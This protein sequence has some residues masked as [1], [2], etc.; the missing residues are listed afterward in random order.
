[1][2]SSKNRGIRIELDGEF[3]ED[4]GDVIEQKVERGVKKLEESLKD[5]KGLEIRIEQPGEKTSRKRRGRESAAQISGPIAI[6]PET[7][8]EKRERF[9]KA[10]VSPGALFTFGGMMIPGLITF[11]EGIG[12]AF[13]VAGFIF[14]VAI[15]AGEYSALEARRERKLRRMI[16]QGE[17]P[18]Y[19][20]EATPISLPQA[21]AT[22][23]AVTDPDS[24]RARMDALI[25]RIRSRMDE[26][27]PAISV[28]ELGRYSELASHYEAKAIEIR[29]Y[30]NEVGGL[31]EAQTDLARLR[32][33]QEQLAPGDA[34][35]ESL[36]KLISIKERTVRDFQALERY[37]ATVE[38][39]FEEQIA[40]LESLDAALM[41]HK[42]GSFARQT[43]ADETLSTRE[44]ESLALGLSQTA[45]A[46]EQDLA[47]I[48]VE[49]A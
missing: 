37:L 41:R 1:M 7:D 42:L 25:S 17:L 30:L 45:D 15:A 40:H 5:F 31:A 12:I 27:Q 22:H 46:L 26:D 14:Y 9:W 2:G 35:A 34:R 36:A 10:V 11:Q 21:Y 8:V 3:L 4:I 33:Q 38:G 48:N 19:Q 6:P 49:L 23:A 44:V 29:E 13:I 39:K 24:P 32:V 18:A 20:P 28:S 16:Q 43:H 47:R